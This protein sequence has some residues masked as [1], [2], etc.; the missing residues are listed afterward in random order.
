MY[1]LVYIY[2]YI[3]FVRGCAG[4]PF[5]GI[6]FQKPDLTWEE[7]PA[8]ETWAFYQ[9]PRRKCTFPTN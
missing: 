4:L 6:H 2:I 7:V 3:S 1:I 8:S 9:F 5:G